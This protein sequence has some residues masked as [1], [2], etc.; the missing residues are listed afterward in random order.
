MSSTCE[1]QNLVAQAERLAGDLT[2]NK[3]SGDV[4]LTVPDQVN[5]TLSVPA[6]GGVSQDILLTTQAQNVSNKT[7]TA[8]SVATSTIAT[9]TP[10]VDTTTSSKQLSVDL[11]TATASTSTTL[12][13]AQTANRIVAFPDASGTAGVFTDLTAA[14]VDQLVRMDGANTMQ[15]S[16]VT[17]SDAGALGAVASVTG[18]AATPLTL[19][20]VAGQSVV[21]TSDTNVAVTNTASV[22][23][24]LTLDA[25]VVFNKATNDLTL[26]VTDQA[27]GAATLT[28]PDLAGVSQDVVV[29]TLAQNVSNKTVADSTVLTST[30]FADTTTS[31]KQVAVDLATATASTTTTLD[32]NQTANRTIAFPDV[33][34]TV[35]IQPTGTDN[36]LLRMDGTTATQASSVTLGDTGALAGVLSVAGSTGNDLTLT[37]P[38][39]QS[40]VLTSDTN[41]AI[42]NSASVGGNVVIQGNLDVKG[43]TTSINSNVVT[44]ADNNLLLSSNYTTAAARPG[45]LSVNYLPTAVADTIDTGAF[46][47]TTTIATTGAATFTAGDIILVTGANT[48]SNN[49][50][51]EVLTHA[52]NV[53]TIDSSPTFNF[54]QN[55]FVVDTVVAGAITQVNVAVLQ[56]GVDGKYE[57]AKGASTVGMTFVDLALVTDLVVGQWF[58]AVLVTTDATPATIA[59]ISPSTDRSAVVEVVYTARQQSSL[60]SNCGQLNREFYDNAG[61][62]NAIGSGSKNFSNFGGN[63]SNWAINIVPSGANAI[64]QVTGE[65]STSI[66]WKVLYRYLQSQA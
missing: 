37:A 45:G 2:F 32:F 20:S 33:D 10:F 16:S 4:V 25:N 60:N 11:A 3:T 7:I 58:E 62:L 49:G 66:N 18:K 23:G 59:T 47:S 28:V 24:N 39:G 50:L 31:T 14:A 36:Q 51:Y 12:G 35:A 6:M 52:A 34:G 42:T 15:V 17:L 46:V 55:V 1:V 41:V 48:E 27:T 40:L 13:F 26:A 65:A 44:I 56:A 22:G 30:V 63:S 64:I 29:T 61:T 38:A 21:L 54:L 19:Q 9:D 5:A 8:S 57:V 53:L 43:T